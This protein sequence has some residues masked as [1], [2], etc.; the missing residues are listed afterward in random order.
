[1]RFLKNKIARANAS[2]KQPQGIQQLPSNPPTNPKSPLNAKKSPQPKASPKRQRIPGFNYTSEASRATKNIVKNYGRAIC[3]FAISPMALPYLSDILE[4]EDVSLSQFIN[5]IKHI[6]GTIDGLFHFRSIILAN[7]QDDPETARAKRVFIGI[8]EVFI[9]FFSAN[10]IYNSR[11]FHK[12]AHLKF[13]FKMLRRIKHPELF[14]YLKETKKDK[15]ST[16]WFIIVCYCLL[17][18]C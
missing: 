14:T 8:S 15:T 9:K 18:Y 5:Y 17:A 10:W 3:S 4:K 2:S 12:E 11:V 6:K 1:M 16:R 13:R 7:S